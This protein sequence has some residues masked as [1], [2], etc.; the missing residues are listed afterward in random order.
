[1]RK[2]GVF[3]DAPVDEMLA[4]V[5]EAGLDGVQFSG[6]QP[7]AVIDEIRDAMPSLFITKVIRPTSAESM[8]VASE[9]LAADALLFDPK[10]VQRP[11]LNSHPIPIEWLRELRIDRMIVAGGLNPENV[12]GVVSSIRP[13]GIDVS[14]GVESSAGRK[15]PEKIR[16]FIRAVREAELTPHGSGGVGPTGNSAARRV[17]GY[18]SRDA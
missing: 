16:E 5:D 8:D 6:D 4:I 17:S 13:W 11:E 7:P 3:V 14:S 12:G 2:F 1:V 18:A 10:D 9:F 15:D